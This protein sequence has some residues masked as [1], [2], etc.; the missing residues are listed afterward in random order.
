MRAPLGLVA[1]LVLAAGATACAPVAQAPAA[2]DAIPCAAGSLRA[3]G[4]SAQTNAVNTW[5]R[6]YQVACSGATVAYASTGS[7][8][9]VRAF[10]AGT[11]DFAGSDSPLAARQQ[12]AADARCARGPAVHLPM[13]IGPIA[14]A[15]NVAGVGDLRLAPAT[16]ARIFAGTVTTWDDPVIAADNPEAVLPSTAIRTVHRSDGS[17]TTANFTAFLAAT[18]PA[19]WRFGEDSTWAAPGGSAQRGS[20]GVASTV[21][22]TDG[23]IGY[24]EASYARFHNLAVARVRNGAGEFTALTDEAAG[25]TVAAAAVT[26]TGSDL[27]LAVDYRT[28]A[29]GAYPIVLVTYEVVCRTGTPARSLPL[30]RGFLTYTAGPQGQAAAAR[31]G[32]TPL[33]AALQGK[34]LAAVAALN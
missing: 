28:A 23:A 21:A 7:G 10:L 8:A 13:V 14:L 22:R 33:P 27:R 1:A 32:Y 6:N 11:G 29:A 9:G 16:V 4:S 34:V 19:D 3:Q 30:L 2:A 17:G 12:T 31:L 25:R 18:A 15:H 24:V 20:N 5:I 26:G